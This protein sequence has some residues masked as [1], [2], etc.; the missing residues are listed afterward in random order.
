MEH[1]WKSFCFKLGHEDNLDQNTAVYNQLVVMYGDRKRFYHNISHIASMLKDFKKNRNMF[2]DPDV[3]E[4]A[5]WFH[6][7]YYE[8]GK[9]DNEIKSAELAVSCLRKMGVSD[10]DFLD[11][12]KRMVEVSDHSKTFKNL[13]SDEKLFID[14]DM[15]I[16]GKKKD[17][18]DRY[19]SNVRQEYSSFNDNDYKSGRL[20]FLDGMVR[21]SSIYKTLYFKNQ[22]EKRAKK[23]ITKEIVDLI[24]G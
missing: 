22:Y 14:L 9:K 10:Q 24:N 12:V 19:K 20:L 2:I 17:E 3:C 16:L 6:D 15:S 4:A 11:K 23:N 5:I 18:Y 21:R 7:A 1:Q 8:I 13:S